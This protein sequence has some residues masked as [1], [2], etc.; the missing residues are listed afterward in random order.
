[1]RE[2]GARKSG[3]QDTD[4][5]ITDS[6]VPEET[7]MQ[8]TFEQA[9]KCNLELW[10]E[11]APIHARAYKAGLLLESFN[12]YDRLFFKRFPGMVNCS[13]RWYCLPHTRKLPLMFTVRARKPGAR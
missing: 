3:N 10:D 1:M 6:L 2:S 5:L 12:E 9:E 13:E 8:S 11:I 7:T 4:F